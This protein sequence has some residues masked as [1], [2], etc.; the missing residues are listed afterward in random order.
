MSSED[1]ARPDVQAAGAPLLLL[2]DDEHPIH[3]M[4][5]AMLSLEDDLTLVASLN[6]RMATLARTPEAEHGE[7]AH[8]G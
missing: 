1:E 8:S 5:A 3:S 2:T 4:M 7:R 6:E